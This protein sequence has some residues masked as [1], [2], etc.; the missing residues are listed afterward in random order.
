MLTLLLVLLSSGMGNALQ[1]R[2]GDPETAV[3]SHMARAGWERPVAFD[4]SAST[5][6]GRGQRRAMKRASQIAA[7]L[8]S[9]TVVDR[10]I[11]SCA[12]GGCSFGSFRTYVRMSLPQAIDD[13]TVRINV[14]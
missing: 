7:A 4:R 11:L 10:S 8:D 1:A 13:S 5:P 2:H 14:P 9:A 6:D 3:A 12:H